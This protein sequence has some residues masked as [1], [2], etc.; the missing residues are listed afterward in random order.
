M[1]TSVQHEPAIAQRS[2]EISPIA[3]GDR[4]RHTRAGARRTCTKLIRFTSEELDAVAGRAAAAGRPVACFIRESAVGQKPKA[5]PGTLS[6]TLI[7]EL[8][9]V[10]TRLAALVTS[11]NVAG[12]P[13]AADFDATVRDLLDTIRGIE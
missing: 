13:N 9:R 7:R 1:V 2:E 4:A 3:G 5:R 6:D 12:L 8:A 10:A 11:A